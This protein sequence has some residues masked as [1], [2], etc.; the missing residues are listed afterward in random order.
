MIDVKSKMISIAQLI[1]GRIITDET[2]VQICIKGLVLG[3]P[4][5]LEA[6]R[7]NF[8]FGVTYSLETCLAEDLTGTQSNHSLK[9][10]LTPRL[11]RGFLSFFSRL[12]LLESRGQSLDIPQID[13]AFV[14]S[15]NRQE[16]ARRLLSYP[17]IQERL[18]ELNKYTKFTE[19]I[20][21]ADLGVYLAQPMSFEALDL[22]V[23][24][25]TFRYMAEIG[26]VLTTAFS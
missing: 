21:K 13:S 23:C 4:A 12:L 2:R 18:F 6:V 25:Q 17:G 16:M 7:A 14:C 10:T 24:I 26:Q 1:D 8:P 20:I 22:D 9:L 3:F 15:Y 11:V 19:L 5:T